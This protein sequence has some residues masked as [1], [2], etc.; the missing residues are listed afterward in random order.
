MR[1][2]DFKW[3]RINAYCS[4]S[5]ERVHDTRITPKAVGAATNAKANL[6]QQHRRKVILPGLLP[7]HDK[8][9]ACLQTTAAGCWAAQ[10]QR[11]RQHQMM[12]LED[13]GTELSGKVAVC[14]TAGMQAAQTSWCSPQPRC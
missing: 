11:I 7:T 6:K 5:S 12:R 9:T 2:S 8:L 13:I 10:P 3:Q 4:H 1:R 14:C